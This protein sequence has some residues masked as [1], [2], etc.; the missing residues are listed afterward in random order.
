MTET[1]AGMVSVGEL[2]WLYSH[3]PQ[4]QNAR[5]TDA[6][7]ILVSLRLDV[8]HP[9][10]TPEG[11]RTVLRRHGFTPALHSP[12]RVE[13]WEHPDAGEVLIPDGVRRD[14]ALRLRDLAAELA[15]Q[16]GCG[17][18]A[19]MAELIDASVPPEPGAARDT[20]DTPGGAAA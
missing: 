16:A 10:V 1:A 20:E 18:V 17:V 4:A 8:A 15:T 6:L 14:S 2:R 9:A 19:K 11:V 3:L 5:L 12:A 13:I 7:E